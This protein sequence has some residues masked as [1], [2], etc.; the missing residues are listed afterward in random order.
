MTSLHGDDTLSAGSPPVL[1]AGR[2]RARLS[3]SREASPTRMASIAVA[4]PSRNR[5]PA[6]P[7]ASSSE[8]AMQ[9]WPVQP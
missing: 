5:S 2:H 1:A 9:R 8:A 7:T 4:S 3:W 6:S